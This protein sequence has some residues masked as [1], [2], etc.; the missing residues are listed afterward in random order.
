MVICDMSIVPVKSRLLIFLQESN[1][2][3]ICVALV[4]DM[5]QTSSVKLDL[6]EPYYRMSQPQSYSAAQDQNPSQLLQSVLQ[7]S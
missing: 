6:K 1:M 5:L 3:L 7:I 4:G 2:S